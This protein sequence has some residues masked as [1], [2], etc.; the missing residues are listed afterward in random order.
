[1]KLSE[2]LNP[3]L[4]MGIMSSASDLPDTGIRFVVAIAASAGGLSALKAILSA[5]PAEFP[6]PIVVVQHLAPDKPSYLAEI[7]TRHSQLK[8]KQAEAGELLQPGNVY[9]APPDA[10]LQ[11]SSDGTL[12]LSHNPQVHFVRPSAD[13][14]FESLAV[15]CKTKAIA[16][17]LSGTGFDG[18][19]GVEVVKANGGTVVVQNELTSEHFGMP[20]AAILTGKVDFVL[21]LDEISGWLLKA[22]AVNK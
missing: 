6:A 12:A 19:S 16:I 3:I 22:T 11:V 15:N 2:C 7:L 9:I 13:V 4:T 20:Q 5:L 18:A 21:P 8:I 17:V 14:L 10:H 1:M